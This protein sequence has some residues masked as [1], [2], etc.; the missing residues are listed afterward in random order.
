MFN[1]K[2]DVTSKLPSMMFD[3]QIYM[4]VPIA[5]THN[6]DVVVALRFSAQICELVLLLETWS[7]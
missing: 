5:K 1:S 4:R 2:Q 7:R 6:Y 3:S